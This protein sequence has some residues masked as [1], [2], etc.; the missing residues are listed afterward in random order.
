MLG[1]NFSVLGMILLAFSVLLLSPEPALA[2]VGPGVDV[3]FIQTFFALLA[4]A[5]AAFSAVLMWPIYSF[6]RW[7]RGRRTPAPNIHTKQA[8][9]STVESAPEETHITSSPTDQ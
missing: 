9:A 2:Y 5:G 4:V 7:I 3:N 1:R 8:P 6:L